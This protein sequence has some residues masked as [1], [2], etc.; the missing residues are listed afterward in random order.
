MSVAAV[1][2]WRSARPSKEEVLALH[3]FLADFR[4][5]PLPEFW[6]LVRNAASWQIGI[7]P[8]GRALRIQ[9]DAERVGL[10]VQIHEAVV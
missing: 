8:R 2:H 3:R 9:E 4:D 10:V 7:Y 5:R 6:E 1:V